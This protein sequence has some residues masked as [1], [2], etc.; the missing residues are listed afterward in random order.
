ML[1]L[2]ID[3]NFDQRILRGLQLR[4][5]SLQYMVVQETVLAESP[6]PELLQWAAENHHVLVT[7]D[8]T[9][10]LRAASRRLRSGQKVAGLVVVKKEASLSR[11]IDDL[12]VMLECC[13]EAE[14]EN[15]V[16]FIPI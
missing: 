14:M 1:K 2:L 7:H 3:E 5:P 16:V 12:V 4:V 6:D 9:T 13:T 10:M 8:R 11:V 15:Q